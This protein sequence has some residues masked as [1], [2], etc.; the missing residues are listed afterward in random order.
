VS[1]NPAAGA[2]DSARFG[3]VPPEQVEAVVL[4]R[5]WPPRRRRLR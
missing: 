2:I 4:L 5:Y 3:P 1:D